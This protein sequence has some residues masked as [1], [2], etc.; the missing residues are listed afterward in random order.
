MPID[1]FFIFFSYFTDG[2]SYERNALEEWFERGKVTSPMTNLEI[3]GDIMENTVLKERIE[4]FLSD[5]EFDAFDGSKN[6]WNFF[7]TF[8]CEA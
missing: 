7:Y 8:D 4:Q 5:L 2:F 6:E 1:W 3:S